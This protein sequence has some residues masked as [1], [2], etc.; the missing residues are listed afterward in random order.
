MLA[1]RAHSLRQTEQQ[2]MH[3]LKEA[4]IHKSELTGVLEIPI[5][6]GY[7]FSKN[8]R[9][10]FFGRLGTQDR[11]AEHAPSQDSRISKN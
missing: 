9:C 4:E 10:Q 11:A 6:L 5:I 1:D 2:S 3:H 7:K 8:V